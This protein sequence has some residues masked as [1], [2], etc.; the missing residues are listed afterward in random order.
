[1]VQAGVL[2]GVN[3]PSSAAKEWRRTRQLAFSAACNDQGC[4]VTLTNLMLDFAPALP[5]VEKKKDAS[6]THGTALLDSMQGASAGLYCPTR[7]QH[8]SVSFT[9]QPA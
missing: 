6:E 2:S 3:G 8:V 4:F 5:S 7:R 9:V 1:M